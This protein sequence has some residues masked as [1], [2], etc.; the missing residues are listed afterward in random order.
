MNDYYDDD[1]PRGDGPKFYLAEI[2]LYAVRRLARSR[3][4]L[5]RGVSGRRGR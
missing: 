4:S 1:L 5:A 3:K 2:V